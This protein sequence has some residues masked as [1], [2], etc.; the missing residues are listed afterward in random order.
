MT[1]HKA[2]FACADEIDARSAALALMARAL[3]LLDRDSA[4]PGIAG[5]HLQMAID[6]LWR[7]STAEIG[8]LGLH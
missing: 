7:G 2:N 3:E 5:A 4:I 1:A 6:S 8:S